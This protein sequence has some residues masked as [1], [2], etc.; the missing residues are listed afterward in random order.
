MIGFTA[1]V[2]DLFNAGHIL[3]LKKVKDQCDYLIVGLQT[4]PTIDRP[5][6]NKP[7]QSIIERTIQLTGCKYIDRT[8]VYQT[9]Q[10]LLDI[11]DKV[12]IDIRFVGHDHKDELITAMKQK[13]IE[14]CKKR[15]IEIR[16]LERGG[17]WSSSELRKRV[18]KWS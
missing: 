12:K 8:I 16:Y 2:F 10:D 7:V 9:E 14:M 5:E 11:L 18:K 1:G 17:R 4:D 13:R 6:K 3:M 15:G